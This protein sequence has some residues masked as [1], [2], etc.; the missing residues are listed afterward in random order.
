MRYIKPAKQEGHIY[1]FMDP[2][3]A[4]RPVSLR[5]SKPVAKKTPEQ[6][7]QIADSHRHHLGNEIETLADKL[8]VSIESLHRIHTGFDSRLNQYTFPERNGRGDI[9]GIA[10]RRHDDSKRSIPGSSR[11]ITVPDGWSEFDTPILLVEGASDTAAAI[12]L[13]IAAL[14]RPGARAGIDHLADLL[15]DIPHNRPI[16]VVGERDQKP[17]GKWPGREGMIATGEQ[18]TERLHRPVLQ[19]MPPENVKDIR[20]YIAPGN[21]HSKDALLQMIDDTANVSNAPEKAN[22]AAPILPNGDER[23]LSDW[24]QEISSKRHTMANTVGINL[25]RSPTGAGKNYNT[26]QAIKDK[27]SSLTVVPSHAN[28]RERLEEMQEAGIDVKAYPELTDET[29]G[30]FD[31]AKKHQAVGLLVGATL[32]PSCPLAKTC[33]YQ[34]QVQEA[35]SA[36]H[37]IATHE[38]ARIS[39]QVGMVGSKAVDLVIVDEDPTSV[40]APSISVKAEAINPVGMLA[41]AIGNWFEFTPSDDQRSF[42]QSMKTVCDVINDTLRN[43]REPGTTHISPPKADKIPSGWQRLLAESL[44][45]VGSHSIEANALKLITRATIGE[46]ST[47]HVA[48]DQTPDGKLN[49]FL[50]GRYRSGLPQEVPVIATDATTSADDLSDA[51]GQSVTDYTPAGYIRPAHPVMQVIEDITRRTS[52]NKVANRITEFLIANPQIQRLGVIGHSLHIKKVKELIPEPYL[53]RVEMS[54][55]FGQGPD[56]GSNEWHR[57]CEHLLV[58]GTPRVNPG[59]I[60][61]WLVVHGRTAAASEPTGD[62]GERN[63]TGH[64]PNGYPVV[65]GGIGYRNDDWHR[66]YTATVRASIYQAVGRA[67]AIMEDGIPVTVLSNE[68]TGLPCVDPDQ[69]IPTAARETIGVVSDLI[70]DIQHDTDNSTD[71]PAISD[72][73]RVNVGSHVP[74]SLLLDKLTRTYDITERQAERRLKQA[75]DL[76]LLEKPKRGFYAIPSNPLMAPESEEITVTTTPE[77]STGTPVPQHVETS[78]DLPDVLPEPAPDQ[79][80]ATSRKP[81]KCGSTE[82]VLVPIHNGQSIRQ[83]CANCNRFVGFA[84]WQPKDYKPGEKGTSLVRSTA[85][86]S[87]T[88]PNADRLSF[89]QDPVEYRAF[90]TMERTGETPPDLPSDPV[91]HRPERAS[92]VPLIQ[93]DHMASRHQYHETSD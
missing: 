7:Q 14:G 51:T 9:V 77:I 75:V 43:I 74:T 73:Y 93:G 92:M 27:G 38:R 31:E 18:L 1:H 57:R 50:V 84:V 58:L 60:R 52:A 21:I 12:T 49:H 11:A 8:G 86:P 53:S 20:S 68:Q 46:L 32:C 54:C 63:W 44:P 66:G 2:L 88:P 71:I 61:R 85:T 37:R 28:V 76:N 62:W 24:R 33:K 30:R 89:C 83:D 45:K 59:D 90:T 35:Q 29:C 15:A 4:T 70:S 55:Y 42:A 34:Q 41:A 13:G 79:E 87:R 82:V 26:T 25:D 22:F 81:C 72:S 10:T 80:A 48:T 67:R 47:L 3:S 16:V 69:F 91:N 6:W 17:D 64:R 78:D 65:Y 5:T 39:N 23:T 40:L 19:W 56:R 36:K